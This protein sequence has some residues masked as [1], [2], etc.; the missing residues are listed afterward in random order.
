MSWYTHISTAIVC[1]PNRTPQT[2][3]NKTSGKTVVYTARTVVLSRYPC[4]SD[5]EHVSVETAEFDCF[6]NDSIDLFPGGVLIDRPSS[7]TMPITVSCLEFPF[8]MSEK[9]RCLSKIVE[10]KVDNLTHI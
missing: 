3:I 10:A 6:H 8:V 9:R 4:G 5:V 2:M 1:L 7:E